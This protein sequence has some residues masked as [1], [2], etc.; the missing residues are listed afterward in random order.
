MILIRRAYESDLI[1]IN[2]LAVL[3]GY[4]PIT[5]ETLN[6]KDLSILAINDEVVLGFLWC[7]LM[8]KNTL[9]Y[10]DHFLVHPHCTKKGLG[11]KLAQRMRTLCKIK[12]VQKV[13][14]IIAQSKFHDKSAMNALKMA[15]GAHSMPY[16]Y[17]STQI[18]RSYQEVPE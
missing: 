8:N 10:L 1:A 5:R 15:M 6:K 4:D 16:T 14:G 18:E 12:G 13:F 3:Y 11:N 17:V 2:Q 9:G 7:G